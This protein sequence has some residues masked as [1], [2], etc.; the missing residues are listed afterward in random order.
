MLFEKLLKPSVVVEYFAVTYCAFPVTALLDVTVFR[1]GEA[2]A[3]SS[4]P[5]SLESVR[6]PSELRLLL[7]LLPAVAKEL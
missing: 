3:G 4:A 1:K 2:S 6:A 5:L 7:L